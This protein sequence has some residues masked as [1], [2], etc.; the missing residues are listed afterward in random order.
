M[1]CTPLLEANLM[2]PGEGGGEKLQLITVAKMAGDVCRA[3]TDI[4][5]ALTGG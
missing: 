2:G 5:R 4:F 1:G 3:F